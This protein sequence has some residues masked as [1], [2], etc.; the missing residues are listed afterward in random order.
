[1]WA[2]FYLYSF[3]FMDYVHVFVVSGFHERY[4]NGNII[5]CMYV[6]DQTYMNLI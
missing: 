3:D 1:M 5:H 6:R 2:Y 4:N